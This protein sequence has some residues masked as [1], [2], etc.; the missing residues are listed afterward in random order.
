MD[1]QIAEITDVPYTGYFLETK[2]WRENNFLGVREN[3][4]E[5]IGTPN[6]VY[7]PSGTIA[8]SGFNLVEYVK[9][10]LRE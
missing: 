8:P 3:N 10:G 6:V 4:F 9:T 1:A 5:G 2:M 7:I